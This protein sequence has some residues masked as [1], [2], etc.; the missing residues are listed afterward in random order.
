MQKVSAIILGKKK[1][2]QICNTLADGLYATK[3]YKV[4]IDYMRSILPI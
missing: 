4:Q 2:L 3:S 1:R